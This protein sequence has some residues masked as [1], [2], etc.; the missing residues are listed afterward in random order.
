M[1]LVP[2]RRPGAAVRTHRGTKTNLHRDAP[3]NQCGGAL[4]QCYAT[5]QARYDDPVNISYTRMQAA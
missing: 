3:V 4:M 1:L 5:A 2:P